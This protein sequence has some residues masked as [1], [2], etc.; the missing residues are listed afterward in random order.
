M[1]VNKKVIQFIPQ[2]L[3]HG[4]TYSVPL[5]SQQETMVCFQRFN[6]GRLK[7]GSS[8][9][10]KSPCPFSTEPLL[11]ALP[12]TPFTCK[13]STYLW[14]SQ[15]QKLLFQGPLNQIQES[16]EW[17]FQLRWHQLQS[18]E[19]INFLNDSLNQ[20]SLLKVALAL[21]IDPSFYFYWQS[22]EG[23]S[24]HWW[25]LMKVENHEDLKHR[26]CGLQNS[27][28]EMLSIHLPGY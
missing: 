17:K 20:A 25:H 16:Q 4:Y 13:A 9:W 19:N 7:H 28:K 1:Q 21:P 26:H 6:G 22:T 23:I 18:K 12:P 11:Y 14:L 8:G 3:Q 10:F 2:V 24:R 27:F 5:E 15:L